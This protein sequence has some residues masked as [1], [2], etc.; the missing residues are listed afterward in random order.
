MYV[1]VKSESRLW[2]VGFYDP[3]GEWHPESDHD[4]ERDAARRVNFLNGG[5]AGLVELQQAAEALF[6]YLP[7]E[8]DAKNYAVENEGTATDWHAAS[9]RLREAVAAIGGK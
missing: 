5:H 1:Y 3:Q 9:I 7:T 8:D 4:N 2:T 6:P